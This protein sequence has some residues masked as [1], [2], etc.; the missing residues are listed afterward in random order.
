MPT[1]RFTGLFLWLPHP[2]AA[3]PPS[4]YRSFAEPLDLT[5]TAPLRLHSSRLTYRL[6]AAPSD[7]AGPPSSFVSQVPALTHTDRL[8]IPPNSCSA[9]PRLP[10]FNPGTFPAVSSIPEFMVLAIPPE[11]PPSS[12][13][14]FLSPRG[15]PRPTGLVAHCPH[16]PPFVSSHIYSFSFLFTRLMTLLTDSGSLT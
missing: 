7:F 13:A 12:S 3:P 11:S 1:H 2:N 10:Q 5:Q 15:C 8:F 4:R 14:A 9:P 6:F 16:F